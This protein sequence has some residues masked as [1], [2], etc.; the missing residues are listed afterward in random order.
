M[1][2]VQGEYG[3]V[4][5]LLFTKVL[6][7]KKYGV[8]LPHALDIVYAILDRTRRPRSAISDLVGP[9]GRPRSEKSPCAGSGTGPGE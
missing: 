9:D 5:L 2:T 6:S 7:S 8:D 1:K 3:V 4:L